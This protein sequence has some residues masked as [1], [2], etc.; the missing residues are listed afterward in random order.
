MEDGKVSLVSFASDQA[1]RE[2]GLDA[3]KLLREVAKCVQGGGGGKPEFATAGG[4]N[5]EGIPRAIELYTDS[6][7]AALQG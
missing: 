3:G 6:V 4:K 1:V 2:L 7:N 5:P